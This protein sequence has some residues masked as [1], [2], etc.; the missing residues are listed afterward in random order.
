MTGNW[1]YE[2]ILLTEGGL[3]NYSVFIK[4]GSDRINWPPWE[5]SLMLER[6]FKKAFNTNLRTVAAPSPSRLSK[7]LIRYILFLLTS[8]L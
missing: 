1:E 8:G 5:M 4:W 3:N 6:A 7:L 2:Y